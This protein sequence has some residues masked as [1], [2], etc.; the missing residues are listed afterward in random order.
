MAGTL[1]QRLHEV[2]D[3][4]GHIGAVLPGSISARTTRC[5]RQGC[6]CRSDPAVLHGPYETWTW[7]PHGTAVT[8]TLTEDQSARLRPYTDAHRRLRQLV[9]EL[10]RLSLE[11]IEDQEHI[12]LATPTRVGGRL[13]KGGGQGP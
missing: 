6:H 5:Q 4:L 3:E 1:E 9:A 7:R 12:Q 11:L 10:E 2:L 13:P 8:R